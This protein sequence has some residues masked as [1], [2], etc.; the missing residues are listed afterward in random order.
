MTFSPNSS[1]PI[2]QSDKR[3]MAF[4][5]FEAQWQLLD[6]LHV[7]PVFQPL[8]LK[9]NAGQPPII[10]DESGAWHILDFEI[11]QQILDGPVNK[12]SSDK[13]DWTHRVDP[14]QESTPPPSPESSRWYTH[15][16]EMF[17]QEITDGCQQ[18][19]TAYADDALGQLKDLGIADLSHVTLNLSAIGVAHL[20]GLTPLSNRPR[21]DFFRQIKK[22]LL[23]KKSGNAGTHFVSKW[24]NQINKR[25]VQRLFLNQE[26]FPI[27]EPKQESGEI[28]L[29][30]TL[31]KQGY[32]PQKIATTALNFIAFGVR[33]T[34]QFINNAFLYLMRSPNLKETYLTAAEKERR[35]ILQEILRVEPIIDYIVRTTREPIEVKFSGTKIVIPADTK[36]FI[37]IYHMNQDSRAVGINPRYIDPTRTTDISIPL[38]ALSFGYGAYRCPADQLA[39]YACDILLSR[40]LSLPRLRIKYRPNINHSSRNGSYEIES[41][42][43]TTI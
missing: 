9:E 5:E 23:L 14:E 22:Y 40:L 34:H 28:D 30:T 15:L 38:D 24:F 19:M 37:N 32:S 10:Q 7:E 11:A 12:L 41:L 6:Q 36:I 26:L 16:K 3:R 39:I 42:I 18:E 20:I 29:I 1:Q 13:I 17:S 4:P 35:K 2:A 33:P 8:A 25:N 43:I 21:N 27:L 31:K